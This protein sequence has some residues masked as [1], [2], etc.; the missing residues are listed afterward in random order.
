MVDA[1]FCL[2]SKLENSRRLRMSSQFRR[3]KQR[4]RLLGCNVP[5]KYRIF[6]LSSSINTPTYVAFHCIRN[7][8]RRRRGH[9]HRQ[10]PKTLERAEINGQEATTTAT[11]WKTM[12]MTL[13]RSVC[14]WTTGTKRSRKA[15]HFAEITRR[16]RPWTWTLVA[17]Q[18][19]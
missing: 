13:L 16:F 10:Q 1:L 5:V 17:S 3:G 8:R 12:G 2:A 18:R 11:R 15:A 14:C 19:T 4:P 9:H 7:D 6:A